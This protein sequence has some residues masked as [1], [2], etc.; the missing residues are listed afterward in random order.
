MQCMREEGQY[1]YYN[2]A[3]KNIFIITYSCLKSEHMYYFQQMFTILFLGNC[4]VPPI[5][6]SQQWKLVRSENK[7]RCPACWLKMCLR[8][9][10]V[11]PSIRAGLTAMLPPSMRASVKL[12]GP[13]VQ[14]NPLRL[15][16]GNTWTSQT[17]P[18]LTNN[19]ECDNQIFMPLKSIK[20]S[21]ENYQK[22]EK[23]EKGEKIEK[24]EVC[25]QNDF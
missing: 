2:K 15:G 14:V 16:T 7:S 11:P 24:I 19:T 3:E 25:E 12:S 9:F 21:D 8:A 13:L 4:I 1:Q 22:I 18:A 17:T 6:R 5:V 10:Q 23:V 20:K